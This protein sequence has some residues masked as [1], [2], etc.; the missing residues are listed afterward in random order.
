MKSPNV[1][2][3]GNPCYEPTQ[4]E[5]NTKQQAT[6]ASHSIAGGALIQTAEATMP[7]LL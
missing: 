7:L 2:Q 6:E 3:I 5:K 1:L 4:P